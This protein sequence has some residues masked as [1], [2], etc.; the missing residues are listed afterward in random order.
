MR[1]PEPACPA[2]SRFDP[3]L[4]PAGTAD[5]PGHARRVVGQAVAAVRAEQDDSAVTAEATEEIGDGGLRRVLGSVAAKDAI[6]GPLTEHELHD[7]L[8][9]P[10]E[11]D[12]SAE[13]VRITAAAD[14]RGVA[15]AAR[16]LV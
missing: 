9:P 8:A 12:G 16:C 15:N 7:G 11:R 10:G 5:A 6:D 2:R 4:H 14:E 13:I 1:R 3:Y